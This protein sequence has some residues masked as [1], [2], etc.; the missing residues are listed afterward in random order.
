MATSTGGKRTTPLIWPVEVKTPPGARPPVAPRAP[1]PKR[2]RGRLARVLR[3][4]LL[5][6]LVI[7][8]ILSIGVAALLWSWSR[9]TSNYPAAHFNSGLNAVWLEHTWSGSPHTNADY[10]R[11]A[12]A[13]KARQITF[14]YAHVGPLDSNG[15]IPDDR[16]PYAQRFTA[17][18]HE[19]LP[20]LH[21][22]AWIGQNEAASGNAPEEVVALDNPSVRTH[23]ALT[24]A[25]FVKVNG[26]DGV[27]Y[28]I[29]P[30]VNNDARFLDLLDETR[31]ALPAGAMIS[32]AGQKW[33]PNARIA[34]WAHQAG[35]ADAW[36]TSYYYSRV[37]AYVDQIAVMAYNTAM[38]NAAA[39]SLLVKQQTQNILAAARSVSR[40]PQI[41]LG[42][43]T[44]P[45]NDRWY[46]D[47]AENM[48]S[49]LAGIAAGLNSETESS[50]FAGVAIYRFAL[51]SDDAW[52]TYNKVW[53]GH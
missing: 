42:I 20:T 33:A 16:A 21:I 15:T 34:D 14:V 17:A 10:D 26:F 19:R 9:T 32:I 29:E 44:Y 24:A 1:Q 53:L 22:L 28:D 38:P 23:I 45:G 13:L 37:A 8:V 36:W 3:R 27:H 4:A 5:T 47:S 25:R 12:A 39:Y 50:P 30:I 51:T 18:M 46:H 48:A 7:V 2:P 35:R 6:L 31:K 52:N 11:L 40:P 49:G 43:P 41:L